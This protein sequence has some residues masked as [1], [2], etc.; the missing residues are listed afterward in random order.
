MDWPGISTAVFSCLITALSTIGASKQKQFMR[1]SGAFVGGALGI[2]SLVF[3]LPSIDSVTGI[4]LVIAP[5]TAFSAWFWTASPRINCF[6]I[7]V[8]LGFYLTVLQGFSEG[9][10]AHPSAEDAFATLCIQKTNIRVTVF[11]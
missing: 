9:T 5:G 10:S 11:G 8:A 2:A 1:L 7:H 3:I 6:G 4:S